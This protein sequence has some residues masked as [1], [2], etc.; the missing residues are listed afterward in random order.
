MARAGH[1]EHAEISECATKGL[2]SRTRVLT[3]LTLIAA[4]E[5]STTAAIA[6]ALDALLA[7]VCDPPSIISFFRTG[8]PCGVWTHS[9]A[10]GCGGGTGGHPHKEATKQAEQAHNT[11]ESSHEPHPYYV[12]PG[13][14]F[15]KSLVYATHTHTSS[16][17]GNRIT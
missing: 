11:H 16:V 12:I 9:D 1:V 3:F 5:Q 4:L 8:H 7:V 15:E 2:G 10:G 13:K 14:N 17:I 6:I